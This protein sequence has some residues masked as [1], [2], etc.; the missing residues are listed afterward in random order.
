MLAVKKETDWGNISNCNQQELEISQDYSSLLN[1]AYHTLKEP[2]S[3]AQ[4]LLRLNHI[5]AEECSTAV[6]A[7]FLSRVLEIRE[8]IEEMESPQAL[9]ASLNQLTTESRQIESSLTIAFNNQDFPSALSLAGK[10]NFLYRLIAE[11]RNRL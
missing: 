5:E 1:R 9:E 3:R 8:E 11:I 10:Q 2:D 4:Y 6:D 7:D